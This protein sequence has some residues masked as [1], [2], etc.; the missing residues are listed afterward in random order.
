MFQTRKPPRETVQDEARHASEPPR[1]KLTQRAYF[2]A[3][4][5]ASRGGEATTAPGL[6]LEP[7]DEVEYAGVPG[8]HMIPLNDAAREAADKALP[9]VDPV[10]RLPLTMKPNELQ[11]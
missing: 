4:V 3:E 9:Y 8:H 1:Y 5:T 10:E 6:L 2:D 7:G 11:A